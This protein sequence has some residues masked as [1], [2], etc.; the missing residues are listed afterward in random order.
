MMTRKPALLFAAV[1]AFGLS[2]F[3]DAAG[4][5]P[6]PQAQPP[7]LVFDVLRNDKAFGTHRIDFESG[8][9]G[10]LE[11]DVD[12]ELRAGFGPVTVFRYEHSS[13]ERWRNGELVDI[14]GSTLKDGDRDSFELEG[15][16]RLLDLAPSSHWRGYDPATGTI[17]NTETG[18]PM[19]VRIVDLGMDTVETA[20]GPVQARHYRLTG[21]LTVD[22]WY[23]ETGRWVGCEFEARGQTIRYVLQSA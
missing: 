8:A 21:T 7:D 3:D 2:A 19:E 16:D 17:L 12:I 22:L 15:S 20:T 14:S 10:V 23:D 11:V 4:P 18:E 13:E 9:D 5:T 6:M 1:S